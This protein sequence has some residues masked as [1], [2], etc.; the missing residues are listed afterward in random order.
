VGL[1]P[2]NAWPKGET[3]EDFLRKL[4]A[5][6]KQ[7]PGFSIGISQPIIDMVEDAIGG[8]HSPLV[9]RVIGDD[10]NEL[11]RIAGGIVDVLHD[12][13]G[14]TD[15]SIFQEPPIPQVAIDID[16]AA[17]ARYGI[18]VSDITN[19]IQTG[20]GGAAVSKVYVADRTYDVTV[21]FPKETRN[22]PEAIGKLALTTISGAQVPLSQVA[23]IKLQSGESTIAHEMSHRELLV[24]VDY[25]DR[26]LSDYLS[27]AQRAIDQKVRFEPG[28]Y[29]LE[30]GGKFEEQQRAQR[31]FILILGIVLAL[32]VVFLFAEFGKM[33]QTILILMVVPLA[34]LGGLI[35]LHVT[36]ETLN[37]A[38][39]VG[40]IALFGVAV[41]NGIIMIAN[42]NRVREQGLPLREAVVSGAVE[43]FRPVLMTATVATVGMLPAAL[44]TGVGTD[45]QRSLATVV[46]G[47]LLVATLLTLFIL[48]A[49]YFAIEH[50][51]EKRSRVTAELVL[52]G[53]IQ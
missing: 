33:R 43:R 25:R 22:S 11:R 9:V 18:N 49:C 37:V 27:E 1:K 42:I 40:F 12:V 28:R 10:F 53:V 8:A 3:K 47:G 48:P 16:R 5:R 23:R 31:R 45:V 29:R 19:L 34:T 21:R 32:M 41:Q 7:L 44:A 15:A 46:V 52:E 50:W 2:Y 20:V 4:N 30:W 17:A 14:T 6:L 38:S 36:G 26:A 13:R 51:V 35:A 39:A 24:K